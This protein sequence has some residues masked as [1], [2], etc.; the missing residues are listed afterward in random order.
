MA[1]RIREY[2]AD[3]AANRV[4]FVSLLMM[5]Y[6]HGFVWH[7]RFGGEPRRFKKSVEGYIYSILYAQLRHTSHTIVA[8]QNND[9]DKPP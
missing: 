6:N 2:G 3:G 8:L 9:N 5:G 7:R 4:R 1:L